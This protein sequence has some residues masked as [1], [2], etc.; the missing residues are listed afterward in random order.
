MLGSHK[1]K[2]LSDVIITT[3]DEEVPLT[4][5]SYVEIHKLAQPRIYL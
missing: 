3:D 1:N 5:I 4:A 2:I